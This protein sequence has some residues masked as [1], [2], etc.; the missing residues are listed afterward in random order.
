[1]GGLGKEEEEEEGGEKKYTVCGDLIFLGEPCLLLPPL[2]SPL[3]SQVR[4]DIDQYAQTHVAIISGGGGVKGGRKMN[5]RSCF[6]FSLSCVLTPFTSF[7]STPLFPLFPHFP[8]SGHEPA[9]SGFIG[10][11]MLSA[12][13]AGGESVKWKRAGG[14]R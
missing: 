4:H 9:H 14:R 3:C 11:G 10:E 12:V 1:M 13:V 2:S 8:G 6:T 7:P 5:M